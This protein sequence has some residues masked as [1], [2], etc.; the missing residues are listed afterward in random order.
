MNLQLEKD[1]IDLL[2]FWYGNVS[3]NSFLQKMNKKFWE[4]GIKVGKLTESKSINKKFPK[5]L[6]KYGIFELKI[7]CKS[8][9]AYNFAFKSH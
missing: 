7:A 3:K 5:D 4:F 9:K 8:I 2:L 6:R 1:K